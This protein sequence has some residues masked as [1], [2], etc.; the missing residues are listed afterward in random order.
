MKRNKTKPSDDEFLNYMLT[1][2]SRKNKA[3]GEY[4]IKQNLTLDPSDVSRATKEKGMTKI[5]RFTQKADSISMALFSKPKDGAISKNSFV[6][7]KGFLSKPEKITSISTKHQRRASDIQ[8]SKRGQVKYEPLNKNTK[9]PI[10]SNDVKETSKM[11]IDVS[12]KTNRTFYQKEKLKNNSSFYNHRSFLLK[13]SKFIKDGNFI[14]SSSQKKPKQKARGQ[15]L[16]KK[17]QV[18]D[19]N[20]IYTKDFNKLMRE[21]N[22]VESKSVKR[23]KAMKTA[24]EV[25]PTYKTKVCSIPQP[26]A[27]K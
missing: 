24:D 21:R 6:I 23:M 27:I 14:K 1:S 25:F 19:S 18:K 26:K 20:S 17:T 3:S 2:K 7:P 15:S 12:S 13:D 9:T 11:T 8:F 16:L 4:S 10:F 5:K 22:S